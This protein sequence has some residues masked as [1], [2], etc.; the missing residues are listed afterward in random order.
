MEQWYRHN[1]VLIPWALFGLSLSVPVAL[2]LLKISSSDEDAGVVP[3]PVQILLPK[4]SA[5]EAADLPYPPDA[6]PNARDVQSPYGSLRVYEWGPEEGRKVMLIHGISNPCIALGAIAHSLVDKGCRVILFDLPGR[7]YSDTPVPTPHSARLY[8]TTILLA[9][10]SSPISWTGNGNTFSLIGYSLGGGIAAN[11]TSYFPT[12]VSSLILIAPAGLIRAEHF[13]WTNKLLYNTGLIN[14]TTLEQ[15]IARRLRTGDPPT[16]PGKPKDE[17]A[18]AA[19]AT[20]ELPKEKLGV[21]PKM[22][23]LSRARPGLSAPKAMAWQL[24]AHPG[25]VKAFMSGIRYGPIAN[26]H[27]VW[28]RIGQR[29]AAQNAS[30]EER[31]TREGL[32]GGKVLIIG[33]RKDVVVDSDELEEDAIEVLGKECVRFEWVDAGHEL[34]ITKSGEIVECVWGFWEGG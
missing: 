23:E 24:D 5:S 3:S 18:P 8:T 33:G 30:S 10:A 12:L 13:S 26:Q 20:E 19:P 2:R 1:R 21:L 22:A 17:L 7:G 34:P 27:D 16:Q 25:F 11:F 15:I 28:R 31:Y 4:L 32:Q 6:F 29:L 9:L 14:E